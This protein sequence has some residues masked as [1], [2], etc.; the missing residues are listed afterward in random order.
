[1]RFFDKLKNVIRDNINSN[2]TSKVEFNYTDN[3]FTSN[4]EPN[5]PKDIKNEYAKTL[6]LYAH[7]RANIIK[8]N[9][10]Y[11]GYLQYDCGITNPKLFHQQLID[12]GYFRQANIGEVLETYKLPELKELLKGNG[13]TT[14][15]KKDEL[16]QKIINTSSQEYLAKI[17]KEKVYYVLSEK[18]RKYLQEKDDYVKV[19]Q[20]QSIKLY[21]YI[22]E[23]QKGVLN[24]FNDICWSIYNK[25]TIKYS[26]QSNFGM[27]QYNYLDMARLLDSEEKYQRALEMY[28]RVLICVLNGSVVN[29]THYKNM[30]ND[31]IYTKKEIIENIGNM[32]HIW[33]DLISRIVEL[34]VHYSDELLI[35]VCDTTSYPFKIWTVELLKN[36]LDEAFTSAIF[37]KEKYD[38]IINQNVQNYIKKNF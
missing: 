25:R 2:T 1:M 37:D 26:S 36:L 21:E 23:K 33:I 32:S 7:Q 3:T 22:T 24:N 27:V 31:G 16:I 5:I 14:T 15:G 10:K 18:G 34:K 13:Q 4:S 12:E 20:M 30:Y 19:H 38:K 17:E 6:F 8:N 28:I 29:I 9:D 11:V 35:R